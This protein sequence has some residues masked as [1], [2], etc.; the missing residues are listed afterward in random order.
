MAGKFTRQLFSEI[1]L[2]D[3]FFNP[4]K[5]DYPEF[6]VWFQTKA[7]EGRNALVFRDEQG[8]GAFIS[9]KPESE[10]L[11]LK[12][13][14][15]PAL[16]RLKV[17]TLLLAER[18]RGQRLGEGALGLILWEWQKSK[19]EEIYITVFPKHDDLVQ[20]LI[21]FGFQLAGYNGR[22]EHVYIRS[23]KDV[24]FSDP[25]KSFPFISTKFKKGG[26]LI[27]NDT[28]HD[29]LFPYS[30]LKNTVQEQLEMEAANGIT[31]IYV[32]NQWQTHYGIGEPVFIYR[33]YTG[34]AGQPKYKSCLTSFCI[35]S[36]VI[37][38]KRN[39]FNLKTFE[40]FSKVIGNKSIFSR[41]D[42]QI[43]Y[44]H[45]KNLTVIQLLY[46]GYFGCGNNIN[47]D[48]LVKNG[49]WCEPNAYPTNI[50]L[51]PQ[52]CAVIWREGGCSIADILVG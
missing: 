1:D 42:L 10:P 50:R 44:T 6:S 28:Y 4:L 41:N 20:N 26:Y 8:L 23:R 24:D 27:V 32:G 22:G 49:L 38:V 14:K 21:H 31:K 16:P 33:R 11:V 36:D 12:E 43:K 47:M 3:A 2:N 19:L 46:Y 17:S 51:S 25:Y 30:E 29:T 15:I 52:Q 9:L 40:E 5:E 39:G 13:G 35:V 18:F 34:G 37:S 48:W 7:A 45:D